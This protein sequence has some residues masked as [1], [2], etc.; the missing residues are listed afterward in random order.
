MVNY[1]LEFL[2]SFI[3]SPSNLL[4]T[5]VPGPIG[6]LQSDIHVGDAIIISLLHNII[7]IRFFTDV[8]PMTI[9]LFANVL[10]M[11]IVNVSNNFFSPFK[12]IL[13]IFCVCWVMLSVSLQ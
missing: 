3:L 6:L 10:F 12:N 4:A 13:K 11:F 1:S 7:Y 2:S 8:F 5:F 9:K